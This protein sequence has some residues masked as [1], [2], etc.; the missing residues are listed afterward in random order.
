MPHSSA[1]VLGWNAVF[2]LGDNIKLSTRDYPL[3][4]LFEIT[5]SPLVLPISL[6]RLELLE[7]VR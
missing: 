2:G 6:P 3:L 7:I 1:Y 5:I 4:L